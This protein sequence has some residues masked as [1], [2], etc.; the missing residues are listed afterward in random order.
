M[1]RSDTDISYIIDNLDRAISEKWICAYYMPIVRSSNGK[2]CSEEALARWIDPERGMLSPAEFIPVLEESKLIYKLDLYIVEEVLR[3]MEHQ[4]NAGLYVV[5][6]SVNLSRIDFHSCDIVEEVRKRVDE[7]GVDHKL[8][9]IEITESVLGQ[10]L[11]YMKGQIERLHELGFSVWMDD[12]GSGYSS[13]DVLQ[14]INFDLIKFDIKF[15]QNFYHEK[16]RIMLAELTRMAMALNIKTLTEGIETKE[17]A[18]FLREIGC[19][20][21]QGYYFCK[22]VPLE[23]ILRRYDSGTQIGFENPDESSY[24]DVIGSINLYDLSVIGSADNG[25]DLFRRY[26]DTLPISIYESDDTCYKIIRCNRAYRNFT[27]RFL[28]SVHMG[29]AFKYSDFT[30][31]PGSV[32]SDAVKR[33]ANTGERIFF[34]ESLPDGARMRTV[35]RRI[36]VNP[37]TGVAAVVAV[38]LDI[39]EPD[40]SSMPDYENVAS[41]LAGDYIY[42]FYVNAETES[43]V[44]YSHETPDSPLSVK[45]KGDD[46]FAQSRRDA[47]DIIHPE[48]LDRFTNLF[49]K[50]MILDAIDKKGSFTLNYR[51]FIDGE[52]VWVNMKIARM[53]KNEL[54]IGISNIDAQMKLQKEYDKVREERLIFSRIRALTDEYICI[55]IVDPVTC[56]YREINS[57]DE[58]DELRISKSGE[59]FFADTHE[60]SMRVIYPEDRDLFNIMFTRDKMMEEIDKKG[61]F[62]MIYRLLLNGKP[63]YVCLKASMIN[64]GD[65][66]KLIV[67]VNFYS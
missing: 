63:E 12:L 52:T 53:S 54:I 7:A 23:E 15:M 42:L 59:D 28:N 51:E 13:L 46:F 20:K 6:I 55:Y 32:Y 41:A 35:L 48:D 33:C 43:F 66:D 9:I 58:Y 16:S 37:V 29:D 3:K 60:E 44:E 27:E 4:K 10:D 17:Q 64:E 57:T 21:M 56:S 31:G 11:D 61:K 38:I 18:E 65:E 2:V 47:Q 39:D 24:Y 36:C 19:N 1:S 62:T 40:E 5:P 14:E 22:P 26:F 49:H 50:E 67:G 45:Q 25:D 30:D 8:L 34:R